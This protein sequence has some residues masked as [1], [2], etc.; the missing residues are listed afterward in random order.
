MEPLARNALEKKLELLHAMYIGLPVY[1]HKL[2]LM[3]PVSG[4]II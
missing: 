2:F 1:D 4:E 3:M